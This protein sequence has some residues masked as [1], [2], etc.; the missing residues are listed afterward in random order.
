MSDAPALDGECIV[1]GALISALVSMLKA[2]PL[3]KRFPK[4]AVAVLSTII[5]VFRASL[6]VTGSPIDWKVVA[7]CVL[8]QLAAGVTTHE[9]VVHPA[10]KRL[11]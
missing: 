2:I 1:Y 10:K 7:S 8:L 5:T 6:A 9:V 4:L 11:L 3:V